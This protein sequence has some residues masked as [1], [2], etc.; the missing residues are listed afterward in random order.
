MTDFAVNRQ[1]VSRRI[2]ST[3]RRGAAA[4]EM[5][6]ILPFIGLMFVVAVDYCRIYYATQTIWNCAQSA[7]A[8]ASG[9]ARSP[10][11]TGNIL[12]AQQAAVADGVTLNPPLQLDNV[13]VVI[14]QQT[15]TVTIQY[16]FSMLTLVL[17]NDSTVVIERTVTVSLFPVPGS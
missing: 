15:A 7:A 9:T 13:T 12:A 1:P 5:A 3:T 14:G 6:L 11:A 2:A 16:P 10:S 8:Y 17:G 4:A